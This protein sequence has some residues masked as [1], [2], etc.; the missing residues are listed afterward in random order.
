MKE[1][2]QENFANSKAWAKIQLKAICQGADVA[3]KIKQ[4]S[5]ASLAYLGDAVYELYIRTY[6]LLPSRRIAN[7]H[8]RVVRQV[9]AETQA[10]HLKS[11]L[12][13]LDDKELEIVHLCGH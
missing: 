13:R 12:D 1:K 2:E 10:A 8:D 4:L 3:A 6:Y 5:P 11:I 7:Y 9:R